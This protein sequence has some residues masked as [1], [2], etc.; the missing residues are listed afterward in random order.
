MRTLRP[1][2]TTLGGVAQRPKRDRS[3]QPAPWRH[4]TLGRAANELRDPYAIALAGGTALVGNIVNAPPWQAA[5][6]AATVLLVRVVTGLVLPTPRIVSQDTFGL[7]KI[8]LHVADLM[9]RGLSNGEIAA[10]LDVSR[11]IVDRHEKHILKK[12]GFEQR[13]EIVEWARER[14]KKSQEHGI[15]HPVIRVILTV[16]GLI[17]LSYEMIKALSDAI[18]RLLGTAPT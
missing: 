18:T 15:D 8:E 2:E 17:V 9:G 13:W 10:R 4:V 16:G 6:A 12:L 7:T 1:D 14:E 3:D 5:G 11:R